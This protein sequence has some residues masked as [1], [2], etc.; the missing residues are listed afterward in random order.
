MVFSLLSWINVGLI[1]SNDK[2][3]LDTVWS[4][5]DV[6]FCEKLVRFFH[7]SQI[8]TVLDYMISFSEAC[9]FAFLI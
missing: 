6:Q 4:Y 5:M 1:L 2:V 9:V 3:F 8:K 7:T